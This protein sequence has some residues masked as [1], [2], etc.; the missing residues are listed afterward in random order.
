VEARLE[1]VFTEV[2]AANHGELSTILSSRQ[3]MHLP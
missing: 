3:G 2:T 1:K